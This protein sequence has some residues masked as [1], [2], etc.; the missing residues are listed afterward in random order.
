MTIE[1]KSLIS[2]LKTTMKA[3]AVK[4][5]I[6]GNSTMTSPGQVLTGFKSPGSKGPGSKGPGS[7]GPGSKGPGS[8]GPG[9]KGPGSKGPGNK[10][11]AAKW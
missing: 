10:G 1:K 4:E 3:N 6:S 2:A 9:S 7:K 8:K 11:L 5:D